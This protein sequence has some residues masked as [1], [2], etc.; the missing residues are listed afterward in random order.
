MRT[1]C[2]K[3]PQTTAQWCAGRVEN[4]KTKLKR[5]INKMQEKK[6]VVLKKEEKEKNYRFIPVS[7]YSNRRSE[8]EVAM[9]PT[10]IAALRLAHRRQAMAVYGD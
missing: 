8:R 3:R 4:F 9:R 1:I 7:R 2:L 6:I 5:G 10:V